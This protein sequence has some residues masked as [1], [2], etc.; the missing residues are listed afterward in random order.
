MITPVV[1]LL[2]RARAPVT[3]GVVPLTTP[4]PTSPDRVTPPVFAAATAAF[5]SR[6]A[7][8]SVVPIFPPMVVKAEP[9]TISTSRPEVF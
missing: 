5:I 2:P 6:V 4:T 3:P 8:A 1:L 7:R 9:V